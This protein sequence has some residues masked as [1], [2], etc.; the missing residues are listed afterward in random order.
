[1]STGALYAELDRRARRR[2]AIMLS[3]STVAED[4]AA[5]AVVGTLSVP[6]GRDR[7]FTYTLLDDAGGLFKIEG[8]ELQVAA[9]LEV[10]TYHVDVG[11]LAAFLPSRSR[12][13]AIT[14]EAA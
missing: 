3:A 1:M 6:R 14:V 11:A 2:A 10:G 8:D 9:E 13:F 5:G 4:A 12:R 7:A